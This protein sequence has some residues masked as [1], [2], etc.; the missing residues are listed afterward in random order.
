M[1]T[2]A[3]HG[4]L[5]VDGL[6]LVLGYVVVLVTALMGFDVGC[7]EGEYFTQSLTITLSLSHGIRV[8]CT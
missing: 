4:D 5:Q 8:T 6:G 7:L 1:G 3:G 2:S